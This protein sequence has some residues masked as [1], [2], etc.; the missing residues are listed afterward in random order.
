MLFQAAQRIQ[1]IFRGKRTRRN[2]IE[3]LRQ[4]RGARDI[5]R[6]YRGSLARRMRVYLQ[7]KKLRLN[8]EDWVELWTLSVKTLYYVAQYDEY[9]IPS[10]FGLLFYHDRV[11]MRSFLD[12]PVEWVQHDQENKRK[13]EQIA[14]RGYTDEMEQAAIKLQACYRARLGRVYFNNIKKGLNLMKNAEAG[15]LEDPQDAVKA[16]NYALY[17]LAI[18]RD[19]NTAKRLINHLYNKMTERGKDNPFIL[20]SLAIYLAISREGDWEDIKDYINRARKEDTSGR[21]FR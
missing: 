15:H 13:R 12:K 19:D 6:V 21:V 20:Y 11:N 18:T 1:S 7:K 5:Q 16:S 3:P 4:K 14:S 2:L 17:C 10:L 9:I 8:R